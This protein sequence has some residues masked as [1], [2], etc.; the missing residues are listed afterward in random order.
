MSTTQTAGEELVNAITHGIGA[1]LAIVALPVLTILAAPQSTT[2]ITGAAI[3]SAS[4]ILLYLISTLY[5][6]IP[7]QTTKRVF[8]RLDHICIYLAIAGTYTPFTLCV[9]GG[10]LGWIIFGLVWSLA[11]CGI[12][13]KAIFGARYDRLSALLYVVMGWLVLIGIQTL[14]ANSSAAGLTF[15]ILGGLAYTLGVPFYLLDS[16]RK[17]FHSIW[18]CFVLAGS[19]LHVFA[20][21]AALSA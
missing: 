1:A 21:A 10:V 17:W 5:H 2:A 13:F 7:H 3:F 14:W 19:I 16:R 11:L 9:I 8:Q 20:F 4:L 15:L 6:S 18:H 12:I